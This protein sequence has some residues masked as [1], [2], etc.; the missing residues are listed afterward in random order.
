VDRIM[1]WLMAQETST[2]VLLAGGAGLI[3]MGLLMLWVRFAWRSVDP[4]YEAVRRRPRHLQPWHVDPVEPETQVDLV[5]A[6]RRSL[7]PAWRDRILEDQPRPPAKHRPEH[8]GEE[9]RAWDPEEL[10][11]RLERG[12]G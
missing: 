6:P 10:K 5:L 7:D 9:T 4:P 8:V 3:L 1:T 2:V 12:R 11:R